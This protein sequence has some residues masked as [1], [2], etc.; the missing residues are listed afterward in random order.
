TLLVSEAGQG[1]IGTE[2][3]EAVT[4][5]LVL[6]AKGGDVNVANLIDADTLID[7]F[8]IQSANLITLN[9][10]FV[11]GNTV[12][13]NGTGNIDARGEISDSTGAVSLSSGQGSITLAENV[14]ANDGLSLTADA[15]SLTTANL[16]SNNGLTISTGSD[17][18]LGEEV[19]VSAGDL[20]ISSIN[21]AVTTNNLTAAAGELSLRTA[22]QVNLNGS[23]SA[24]GTVTLA[25]TGGS[26]TATGSISSGTGLALSAATDVEVGQID[27]STG[28]ANFVSGGNLKFNQN[29][30]VADGLAA[31]SRGGG[32]EQAKN[33][34][35][36]AGTDIVI[37]TQGGM[38]IA[39]LRGGENVT[40][41]IR[42]RE[43]GD[44][45]SVPV[46]ERVNDPIT[47]GDA[48]AVPDV[49]AGNGSISFLAQVANVGSTDP[50]QNF[51][52]RAGGGIYYGLVSGQF[53]SDD[54]GTSQILVNAPA[55]AALASSIVSET[56]GLGALAGSLFAA[57]FADLTSSITASLQGTDSASSNAGQTSASSSSRS[58]AAS[59]QDDEEEVA[60]VDEAA[61]QNLK[62]YD[63]NPQGIL[64]PEDQQFAYDASGNL[65]FMMAVRS[66][67]GLT[68]S[69]PF[70]KVDLS[71]DLSS[72]SATG[73]SYNYLAPNNAGWIAAAGDD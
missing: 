53:F 5:R 64:L 72:L 67:S 56:S 39:S 21:G 36:N 60:E 52:Q 34:L 37:S 58:T 19:T 54:I 47:F 26:V 17:V 41:A 35:I 71:P 6:N 31:F 4:T 51:V 30:N 68:Q 10:V 69:V 49:A 42:Q 14:T 70:Y 7:N 22:G 46:F 9:D 29:V 8:T 44:D 33:T 18:V 3:D 48:D 32:F 11:G 43:A 61:F 13:I 15:G 62:N 12:S 24:S 55:G 2:A 28:G 40:L 23:A 73:V 45:L 66:D 25:S 20:A 57:D 63:E 16:T 1:E 59:Q 65:Y 38:K 50:E 27:V